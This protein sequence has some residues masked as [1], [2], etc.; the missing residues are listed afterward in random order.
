M[1][2]IAAWSFKRNWTSLTRRPS[3][4]ISIFDFIRVIGCWGIFLLHTR[5]AV[6]G[7]HLPYE[8][9]IK[10]QEEFAAHPIGRLYGLGLYGVDSFF[11]ITGFFL[12]KF[13]ISE[14]LSFSSVFRLLGGRYSRVWPSLAFHSVIYCIMSPGHWNHLKFTLTFTQNYFFL[15]RSSH[16]L[17]LVYSCSRTI[18]YI[19]NIILRCFI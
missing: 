6:L 9:L 2:F 12:A 4:Q 13:W 14:S 5:S 11:L 7:S 19:F 16:T 8:E 15:K 3:K 18:R 17:G 1:G 10:S